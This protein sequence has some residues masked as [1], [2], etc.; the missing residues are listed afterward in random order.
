MT[1]L[2]Q[3]FTNI[4]ASS[5]VGPHEVD[6]PKGQSLSDDYAYEYDLSHT[7]QT[8]KPPVLNVSFYCC[9]EDVAP[10][11]KE[12]GDVRKVGDLAAGFGTMD[13]SPFPS[14]RRLGKRLNHFKVSFNV[15]YGAQEGLLKVEARIN[16]KIV[17]NT[18]FKFA[19][20]EY[21]Y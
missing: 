6:C 9:D 13:L 12:H 4:T 2:I 17:E 5:T 16:G 15:I 20:N 1:R 7:H 18:S 19:K 3:T 14:K 8:Y 10:L 11:R 21:S